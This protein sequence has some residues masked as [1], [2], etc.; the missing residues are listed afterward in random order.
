MNSLHSY[1]EPEVKN[2]FLYYAV[3][4]KIGHGMIIITGKN[5]RKNTRKK[6]QKRKYPIQEER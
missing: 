4:V 3:K 2:R 5:M 6:L 1:I